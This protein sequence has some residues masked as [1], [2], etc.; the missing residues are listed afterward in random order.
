MELALGEADVPQDGCVEERLVELERATSSLQVSHDHLDKIEQLTIQRLDCL[1]NMLRDQAKS[2]CNELVQ[3][4]LNATDAQNQ[5]STMQEKLDSAGIPPPPALQE[6]VSETQRR[7]E[8]Q[9]EQVARL[10]KRTD[11]CL[12]KVYGNKLVKSAISHDGERTTDGK[13]TAAE[14]AERVGGV[15]DGRLEQ[16][17]REMEDRFESIVRRT[18]RDRV[19]ETKIDAVDRLSK[20]MDDDI[21][22]LREQVLGM[23]VVLRKLCQGGNDVALSRNRVQPP[24]RRDVAY[25]RTEL[26]ELQQSVDELRQRLQRSETT[27]SEVQASVVLASQVDE[28]LARQENRVTSAESALDRLKTAFAATRRDLEQELGTLGERIT[29]ELVHQPAAAAASAPDLPATVSALEGRLRRL[30]DVVREDV[31][32]DLTKIEELLTQAR[33]HMD[34][35]L[36]AVAVPLQEA[37]E[38]AQRRVQEAEARVE[39]LQQKSVDLSKVVE[40]STSA[41]RL[42]E[43]VRASVAAAAAGLEER[44]TRQQE[45]SVQQMLQKAER[46]VE[47]RAAEL[48]TR[49]L[50]TTDQMAGELAQCQL[51]VTTAVEQ[52]TKI[53]FQVKSDLE[54]LVAKN[55]RSLQDQHTQKHAQSARAIRDL[56]AR[57]ARQMTT[58]DTLI[59]RLPAQSFAAG[60]APAQEEAAAKRRRADSSEGGQAQVAPPPLPQREAR[61]AGV[62]PQASGRVDHSGVSSVVGVQRPP[63]SNQLFPDVPPQSQ[64]P[65]AAGGRGSVSSAGASSA[66]SVALMSSTP[67]DALRGR[68]GGTSQPH[69]DGQPPPPP[70]S[71]FQSPAPSVARRLSFAEADS[72]RTR[73]VPQRRFPN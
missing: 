7:L 54:E 51:S 30:E 11:A 4:S 12:W 66:L 21:R 52:Q 29:A 49:V 50:K 20:G 18:S 14:I 68:G 59:D 41:D 72:A 63:L 25:S 31:Q 43:S 27:L 70:A 55:V 19:R 71:S 26:Q 48:D 9:S 46:A 58:I 16:L 23:Q 2:L 60:G 22:K 42:A 47:A 37:A 64:M 62:G 8:E 56:E 5:V 1:E 65:A 34:E 24:A 57:V 45:D 10:R 39:E 17:R 36:K 40:Q 13:S 67:R 73:S 32:A 15:V 61:P 38:R 69:A 44:L 28:R 3:V 53:G 33:G 6:A 35:Q